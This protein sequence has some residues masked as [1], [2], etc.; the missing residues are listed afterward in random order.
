M[1]E[2]WEERSA[3][4]QYDAGLPRDAAEWHAYL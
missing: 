1:H 4:M 3:L 2:V